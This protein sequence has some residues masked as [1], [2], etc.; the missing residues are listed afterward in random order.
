MNH[1]QSD[2]M[3]L[4]CLAP[5]R[6]WPVCSERVAFLLRNTQIINTAVDEVRKTE[7]KQQDL[8]RGQ[9]TGRI[10]LNPN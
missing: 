9:V 4:C 5:Q 1:L 7:A 3:P 10:L 6:G 8:L 2:S